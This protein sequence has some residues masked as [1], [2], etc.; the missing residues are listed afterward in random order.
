[1]RRFTEYLNACLE[2]SAWN[3][4][5]CFDD[6]TGSRLSLTRELYGVVGNYIGNYLQHD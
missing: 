2:K 5:G 4:R 3:G 1:M 6:A